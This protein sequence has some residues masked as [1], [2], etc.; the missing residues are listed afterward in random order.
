MAPF[1]HTGAVRY[2]EV[3]QQGVVFNA[4][5]LAYLDEAFSAYM[6]DRGLP[7]GAMVAA[8][9]DIQLVHT[10]LDWAAS[11]HYPDAVLVDVA[12]AALGRTSFTVHF[13]VRSAERPVATASTTY[14]VVGTDGSGAR[15]LP[16]ELRR[17][18]GEP[19]PLRR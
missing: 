1:T 11:L 8:G 18:L 5:Y 14:V 4:W 2:F 7:V 15:P 16:A 17:A 12:L 6:A 13:A 10:E 3:D 19:E 9:F